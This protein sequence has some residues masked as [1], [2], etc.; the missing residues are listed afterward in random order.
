MH[1]DT[2]AGNSA[3][4][5]IR[6]VPCLSESL[7]EQRHGFIEKTLVSTLP[8]MLLNLGTWR[9]CPRAVLLTWRHIQTTPRF[10]S[11][12][13]ATGQLI[14]TDHTLVRNYNLP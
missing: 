11:G 12:V 13:Q 3:I 7:A 8:K 2:A 9:A 6:C 1:T 4:I 5:H 14:I 10:G